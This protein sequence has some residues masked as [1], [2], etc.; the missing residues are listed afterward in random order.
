M[1]DV[2]AIRQFD[3]PNVNQS[4]KSYTH[5]NNTQVS[6]KSSSADAG[7]ERCPALTAVSI[8][9]LELRGETEKAESR[10]D[11][12][13]HCPSSPLPLQLGLESGFG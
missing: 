12:S 7:P 9:G 3:F 8:L 4:I 11:S 13:A 10:L 5:H 6:Q 1:S 2:N